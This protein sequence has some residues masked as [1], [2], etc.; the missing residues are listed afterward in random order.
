[1]IKNTVAFIFGMA[2]TMLLV[3]F[4]IS[5]V[6]SQPISPPKKPT[7]EFELENF[8]PPEPEPLKVTPEKRE[9]PEKPVKVSQPTITSIPPLDVPSTPQPNP[10]AIDLPKL[11]V[12][13]KPTFSTIASEKP[14][15][16]GDSNATPIVQIE[17]RY[18]TNMAASG[19]EG[20]VLLEYSIKADGSVTDVKVIDA[21]P[22]KVFNREAKRA[23]SKWRYRPKLEQGKAV[24]QQ[25]LTIKLEFKLES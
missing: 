12:V 8:Q 10:I 22:K 13:N 25:G 15:P 5:M 1:M 20:F 24:A 16:S 19:Q 9:M 6:Q 21:Q 18:P 11:A 4:M 2:A 23:L 17:P 14:G 7:V 3:L